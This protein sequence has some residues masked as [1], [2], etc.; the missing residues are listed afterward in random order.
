MPL[1]RVV[2][3]MLEGLKRQG[4]IEVVTEDPLQI[5]I[6]TARKAEHEYEEMFLQSFDTKGLVLSGLLADFFE[7]VLAK[8]QEKIWDCDIDATK[9]LLPK[10]AGAEGGDGED[11]GDPLL[12]LL[13]L[14]PLDLLERG[15]VLHVHL[16]HDFTAG[17]QT[18]M[19]SASCFKGCF[20]PPQ[21][22]D[23][24]RWRLLLGVPQRLPLGL[25]PRLSFGVSLGLPLGMPLR[26]RLGRR[27]LRSSSAAKRA[28][29]VT[30]SRLDRRVLPRGAG[31]TS[32]PGRKTAW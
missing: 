23:R 22:H 20:A 9:E 28:R 2:G 12:L 29:H 3:I 24:R 16:P 17:Y 19:A 13:V 27:A 30:V 4:I 18:F 10:E 6:L 7:K 32:L 11:R 31:A 15:G 21:A 26:L 5:K 25:P 14:L 1:Q 8:L